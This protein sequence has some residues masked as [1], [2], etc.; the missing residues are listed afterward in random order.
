MKNGKKY[1]VLDNPS[2]YPTESRQPAAIDKIIENKIKRVVIGILD[3]N[4]LVNGK[5]VKKLKHA[6]IEVKVGVNEKECLELNKFF[7]QIYHKKDTLR[8]P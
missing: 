3:I 7:F 6:G 1:S 8:Q 5:G 2:E 4:P